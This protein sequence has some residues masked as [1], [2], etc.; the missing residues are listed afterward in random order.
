MSRT[1]SE[2][3]VADEIAKLVRIFEVVAQQQPELAA[4]L[5]CAVGMSQL[6]ANKFAPG[7]PDHPFPNFSIALKEI[8]QRAINGEIHMAKHRPIKGDIK[9]GRIRELILQQSLEFGAMMIIEQM[10]G[11][12][13]EATIRTSI[14]NLYREGKLVRLSKGVYR[15]SP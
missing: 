12:T 11:K 8:P 14:R 15:V 10:E 1:Y 4:G 3:E 6:W 9:A 2:I 13:S 5:S 7:H